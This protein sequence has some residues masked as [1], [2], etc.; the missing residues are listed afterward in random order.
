[1]DEALIWKILGLEPTRD[2][3]QIKARYHELL[4]GVNPEDDPEGFKRLRQAFEGAIELARKSEEEETKDEGPKD[5][6]DLWLDRI[7]DIYWYKDTRNDPE[8]WQE[9][10]QDPVCVALDTALEARERFLVFLMSH[11]YL[12]NEIWKMIDKE[13]NIVADQQE[14]LE[15][16][17]KDFLDFICYQ[18]ETKNFF[19]YDQLE[20]LG[21]DE[22]EIQLD[23][24][25]GGYLRLKTQIDR[26]EF[27]DNLW[28]KLEDLKAY[29]VYHPYEDVERVRLYIQD[30]RIEEAAALL[31][32]LEELAE[33]DPYI[34]FWTGRIYSDL[35]NH[36][37]AY[38]YW[39]RVTEDHPKHYISYFAKVEM[40]R[41]YMKQQDYLTAKDRI[42]DLLEVNGRDEGVLALMREVNVPLIEYYHDLAKQ[43]PENKKHA[44]EACWCMFQNEMFQETIQEL[45]ALQ[46]Q[47]EEE[48]YYDYVNMKGRCFLGLEQYEEAIQYLLQWEECRKNLVDD[49]SD[50]YKKRQSREGFIKSAIGAA[51][52][53]LKKFEE[54]ETYLKEGIQLEKD[55][56]IRHSFMDRLAL[57]YYDNEQYERCIDT[58]TEIVEEDPGYYPAYLRRQQ[59]YY[60]MQNGQGV[61]DDYYNAIRIY[62]KHY[63]PYL[64]AARVFCMFRQYEDA[65]K[66]LETAKEQ[67]V[68]HEM[69]K[70]Y[71]IRAL[72][73]LARSEEEHSQVMELCQ[74]LKQEL[75]EKKLKQKEAELSE[76]EVVET[77]LWNDRV[78][79]DEVDWSELAFEEI[80][81]CMNLEDNDAAMELISTELK[82][83]NQDYRLHWVKADIHQMKKEYEAALAEYDLLDQEMPNNPDIDFNK[84]LC[85]KKLGKTE[86]ALQAFQT[87][88]KK[89]D[90]HSRANFELMR[91]YEQWFNDY[92]L[93]WTYGAALKHI[94]AQLELVPD[95]YYYIERG[96]L[97]MDN[98]N[99]DQSIADYKKALELEPDNVY[100][101][102]NIGYVLRVKGEYEEAISYF[103]Q[104][105]EHMKGAQTLLP[106]TNMAKCYE[107]IYQPERGIEVLKE[108]AKIFPKSA[109][110]YKNLAELYLYIRDFNM[111]QKMYEEAKEKEFLSECGFYKSVVKG[112]MLANDTKAA[113]EYFKRW[114]DYT[115]KNTKDNSNYVWEKR[116]EALGQLGSFYFYQRDLKQAAKYLEEAV[117]IAVK[118]DFYYAWEGRT[119]AL[120]Y[121]MMNLHDKARAMASQT[122]ESMILSNHIP[123]KL[124][125]QES[126]NPETEFAFLSYRPLAASR[127]N[128]FGLFH[129]CMGDWD[130]A[131]QYAQ[132]SQG[133]PKCKGCAHEICSDA[134]LTLAYIAEIQGDLPK[135][136]ELYKQTLKY[137]PTDEEAM[138]TIQTLQKRL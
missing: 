83:G 126:E 129:L 137:N 131:V 107:A 69:L 117:K 7:Q 115:K 106:Y 132:K 50:K 90:K 85:L 13:F 125:D 123:K 135:A 84:G 55:K 58:C 104:S 138:M 11:N 53:N 95:A 97:Y 80:L 128:Q 88:L 57:L 51:Y 67:E 14:L 35:E 52:Q 63:K 81:I 3:E 64:L 45:D 79:K 17:P 56:G 8:A 36:E 5:E 20:V 26:E 93:K 86:A 96:L 16:F 15:Y 21:L 112:C 100:A 133:I 27:E 134:L 68:E 46:L 37:K 23:S 49:G 24:Y 10:F 29:Q 77:E 40:I 94:N 120:A 73:N 12:K 102:N 47:P 25:I 33:E 101:Y 122:M 108:A 65:K 118:Y 75:K 76:S 66:V 89:D 1:M 28:Q 110:I 18:I 124:R 105:I 103:K 59:A 87:T 4:L 98:Y 130:R 41:Y 78:P 71:E 6:I 127:L 43:E 119:L 48:E 116:M 109:S 62:A 38:E 99:M 2:E 92:E 19:T 70:F 44:I 42:M 82:K 74:Q 39:K 30:K 113:K 136:L 34:G 9:A 32:K 60:N 22:A 114:L 54:A 91:I 72:R 111:A 61:V 121:K 31:P